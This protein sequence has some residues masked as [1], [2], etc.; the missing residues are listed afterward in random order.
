MDG[1][2]ATK[3][4]Q[5]ISLSFSP[6]DLVTAHPFGISSGT[7][8]D[9][10]NLLV[11]L[12][13]GDFIGY[14][15]ASPVSYH[16]ESIESARALLKAWQNEDLLGDDPF[17]IVHILQRLDRLV[18]D[19]NSVK[20]AIE[21]ALHDLCGKIAAQPTYKMLGLS[22]LPLPITDMTIGIDSLEMIE[23]KTK[24]AL[25]AGFKVLK[26]NRA[27][28]SIAKSSSVCAT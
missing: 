25:A 23:R 1:M 2:A 12:R 24:E 9:S 10:H 4:S 3:L 8:V 26:S 17:A 6:L 27:Q 15:E 14:G 21:M 18:S 19:N 20:A 22:R 7:A 13:H 16:G 5:K 28:V 11:E